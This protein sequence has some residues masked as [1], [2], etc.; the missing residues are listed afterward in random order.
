VEGLFHSAYTPFTAGRLYNA[1]CAP[2]P[3]H[4]HTDI[5]RLFLFSLPSLLLVHRRCFSTTPSPPLG[6]GAALLAF[7]CIVFRPLRSAIRSADDKHLRIQAYGWL[8]AT[9]YAVVAL[10]CPALRADS[11]VPGPS[12]WPYYVPIFVVVGPVAAVL[13]LLSTFAWLIDSI[14]F[15][16]SRMKCNAV[17]M[18][19]RQAWQTTMIWRASPQHH[20][21]P[22][23]PLSFPSVVL[24]LLHRLLGRGPARCGCLSRPPGHSPRVPRRI[25]HTRRRL[26]RAARG[27]VRH[28]VR[29]EPV[30]RRR[31]P[32]RGDSR[33]S[34]CHVG[35]R[36]DA[37]T[38]PRACGAALRR[39]PAHGRADAFSSPTGR[40]GMFRKVAELDSRPR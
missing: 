36:G 40:V 21:L 5:P 35:V 28:R 26:R 31:N 11:A 3:P 9:L 30:H 23:H 25:P 39:L 2:L 19:G 15:G 24:S 8:A 27:R 22:I 13:P 7:L 10:L 12:V 38:F 32:I 37:G 1:I 18:L 34:A 29:A 16:W 33:A 4:G 14:C 6:F 20:L 17:F